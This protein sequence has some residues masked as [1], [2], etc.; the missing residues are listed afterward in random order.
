MIHLDLILNLA[1]LVALSIVSGF[2]DRRWP[3]NTRL[4]VLLQ[5]ALFGGTAVIGM[6]RPLNLGPGLIFDGRSVMVSLGALFFGPWAGAVAALMTAACRIGLGGAGALTGVLVILSSA[7]IGLAGHLRLKPESAPPSAR[8]LYLFG[9][10]VHLAM[11]ALMLTLPGGIGPSV[12]KRIGPPVML[13]YPLATILAGKILSDQLETLRIMEALREREEHYGRLFN[14]GNDP[15]FVHAMGAAGTPGK[16]TEVNDVACARLGH[17]REELLS[18]SPADI[19]AGGMEEARGRAAKMLAK[20][21]QAVFEMVH[22]AKSRERIPVEVSSRVFQ[23]K[24]ERWVLS[25]ARDT[26][27][28][29][30]AEENLR[31]NEERFRTS[32]DADAIGRVLTD[33]DG[34]LLRVNRRFCEMLGYRA[35]ELTN[36]NFADITHP[37]DLAASRECVRCLL[38]GEQGSCRLEKRYLRKEGAVLWAEMHTTLVHDEQGRPV[39]FITGVQDISERKRAEEELVQKVEELQRFQDTVVGRE[40]V[41]VELKKEVNALLKEAGRPEKYTIVE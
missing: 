33:I 3:R 39:H 13:L 28:R 35:E 24:G 11:L 40:L 34:R 10:A 14:S 41:M 7:G 1:L 2:I 37:E 27:E 16:F 21:G 15:A 29:K 9:L 5:G 25:I 36:L 20:T 4:G 26:T 19:D 32:F 38:A 18:M 23:S 12:V 17:S 8:S 30:R 22:V 31:L 6:L